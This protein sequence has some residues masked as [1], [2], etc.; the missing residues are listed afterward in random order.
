MALGQA[1]ACQVMVVPVRVHQLYVRLAIVQAASQ[2]ALVEGN[3][4]RVALPLQVRP[5]G[6]V[7][8]HPPI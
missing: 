6:V 5:C 4:L 3:R 1:E 2:Q 7:N 8:C